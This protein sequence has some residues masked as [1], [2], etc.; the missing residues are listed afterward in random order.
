MIGLFFGGQPFRANFG[1]EFGNIELDANLSETHEWGAD[2]TENPVEEGAPVADHV[3]ERADKLTIRGFVSETPITASANILGLIGSVSDASSR[4]Q[5]VFDLLRLLIK[6]RQVMTVYTKHQTYEDMV[7]SRL[8]IPR[9]PQTGDA[10]EFRAEFVHVRF[11]S[12]QNVDVPKGISAKGKTAS[13]ATARKSAP[14]KD[15][16][17]KA[18]KN[19]TTAAKQ[20]PPTSFLKSLFE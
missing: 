20:Q 16:G 5:Q 8:I 18:A 3:V 15:A 4:T 1:N 17:K 10:I 13:K 12:A 9:T 11:V 2:V 7:L 6:E 19:V 14:A